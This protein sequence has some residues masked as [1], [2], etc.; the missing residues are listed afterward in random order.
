MTRFANKWKALTGKAFFL[1][2]AFFFFSLSLS[3][4][5]SFNK[6]CQ[7]AYKAILS[8]RFNDAKIILNREEKGNPS[9]PVPVYLENYID[10]LTVFIG[11]EQTAFR[12]FTEAQS[13]R[14]DRI[15]KS[16]R[17]SPFYLYCR[18]NMNIQGALVKLKFGEY[19][20]VAFDIKRAYN[21]LKENKS[22]F[23]GFLPDLTGLGMI[24]I[25]AGIIPEN[26]TWLLKVFGMEGDVRQGLSEIS[27]L[28]S[29][30]GDDPVYNL[31][32]IE[33]L[34]NLAVI[35][36]SLGRDSKDALQII[37]DYDKTKT[38][39]PD[40]ANPVMIYIRAGVYMKCGMNDQAISVLG[41]YHE[42]TGQ[43]PFYYLYYLRGLAKLNRL[44]EDADKYLILFL[45]DYHGQNYIKAAYQK[46]AWKYLLDGNH[47]KYD[48]F[49]AKIPARGH[50]YVD[51]DRQAD[52]EAK[53]NQAPNAYLLKS[54]VLFDGGYYTRS[55]QVL[56]SKNIQDFSSSSRDRL[57]YTYRL[58]RIY[59]ASGDYPHALGC[60]EKTIRD[61]SLLPYYFAANAALQ[62]GLIY[63][64]K[65]DLVNAGKSYRL[66]LSMRNDE[67]R[68]SLSQKAKAGL[69]RIEQ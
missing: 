56:Q 55:L 13:S 5:T 33:A 14:L 39:I 27:S 7:D 50:N 25:L 35:D 26:Y 58:G 10:F 19:S 11:E 8:L 21:D 22:R 68:N 62:S 15:D 41:G 53:T 30:K 32:R 4:Q 48:E 47:A 52:K 17:K 18:G 36:A 28:S 6:N 40:S 12:V 60:Y 34:F 65:G 45:K 20:N 38:E 61:G 24:H 51:A 31:L 44:D 49:M 29:Y 2:N 59:Q 67:Y 1:L 3:S 66:C 37:R 9:N 42:D 43:Y 23:P 63:E 54:R 16:D 46:L 69:K 64:E 57:E